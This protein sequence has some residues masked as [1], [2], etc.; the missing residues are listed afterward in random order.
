MKFCGKIV[1]PVR[2]K[3]NTSQLLWLNVQELQE[4]CQVKLHFWQKKLI[5]YGK[6]FSR[7]VGNFH[8][9]EVY[10]LIE[11]RT[12]LWKFENNLQTIPTKSG[13]LF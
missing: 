2:K 4:V 9:F 7:N 1:T 11:P 12:Y 6:K 5:F 10:F 13:N 8:V 3:I